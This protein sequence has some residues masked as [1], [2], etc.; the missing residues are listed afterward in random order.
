MNYRIGIA[1][2]GLMMAASAAV[3]AASQQE[4]R[5]SNPVAGAVYAASNSS[6]GNTLLVFDRRADGR[7]EPAGSVATGGVGTG[8]GLGN[9]GGLAFSRDERWLLAV[10]A[11]SNSVSVF[12][13]RRRRP[14]LVHVQPTGGLRPVSVTE[15]HGVVYVLHAGS[16]SITGFTLDAA[17]RLQPL[18]GS[19]RALS[20]TGTAAAQVAFSPDGGVLAV[21]ERATNQ[22]V[23]FEVDRDGLPGLAQAQPSNGVTP[24]GFAFGKRGQ[25]FVTEAFGGAPGASATSSY[26]IDRAGALSTISASVATNQTAACWLALTPDGRFAYVTNAGSGSISGYRIDVEGEIALLTDDGRTGVTGDGST[27]IDLTVTGNGRF[28]YSLN[29]GTHTIGAFRVS[30]D[31]SLTALPFAEGLPVGANGLVSR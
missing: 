14:R 19:T 17:G 28:V 27:P 21:T 8:A 6:S 7:I 22:I 23:T 11:G 29:S 9:Q 24:F 2:A 10:N 31:G 16:D 26:E 12:D 25:L 4:E 20:G 30:R 1:L 3:G 5:R 18:A 15:S 13:A